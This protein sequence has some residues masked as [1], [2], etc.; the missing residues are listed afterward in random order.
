MA[1]NRHAGIYVRNIKPETYA[2]WAFPASRFGHLTSNIIES[3]NGAWKLIQALTP[4][5]MLVAIWQYV[6]S[7]MAQRRERQQRGPIADVP[8]K[9][10]LARLQKSR[11]YRAIKSSRYL[12]EII[13]HNG[14]EFVVDL[15]PNQYSCTCTK[16][17][18]YWSACS[19]AL[20]ACTE[21]REDPYELVLNLYFVEN[22]EATYA[23]PMAPLLSQGLQMDDLQPP[24]VTR[25]KGRP[26]TKR[27]RKRVAFQDKTYRCSNPWCRQKGHNKNGCQ[28]FEVR[29]SVI[30]RTVN[31]DDFEVTDDEEDELARVVRIA[32]DKAKRQKAKKRKMAKQ[33][34][35]RRKRRANRRERGDAYISEDSTNTISSIALTPRQG[36]RRASTPE[37]SRISSTSPEPF[38]ELV[39][40]ARRKQAD[41][42]AQEEAERREQQEEDEFW[43]LNSG[44]LNSRGLNSG[45]LNSG[46]PE[47]NQERNNREDN[48]SSNHRLVLRSGTRLA[49]RPTAKPAAKPTTKPTAKPAAKP[50]AK[51]TRKRQQE[52]DELEDRTERHPQRQRKRSKKALGDDLA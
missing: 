14:T 37:S 38:P 34:K 50:A 43:S 51:A 32:K 2:Y 11:R 52:S 17:K 35:E 44:G 29:G 33:Q 40:Q 20:R 49:A 31:D 10:L 12:W 8:K 26:K 19:H 24:L 39:E 23:T 4:L 15:N 42:I 48:S 28:T 41:R 6:M 18:E 7:E 3:L 27:I 1:E 47:D 46:R 22:Y 30:E 45:G 5:R 16:F 21:A 9:L 25:A 36:R 13:D